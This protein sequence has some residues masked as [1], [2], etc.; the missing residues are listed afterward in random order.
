MISRFCILTSQSLFCLYVFPAFSKCFLFL[1]PRFLLFS[2]PTFRVFY[3]LLTSVLRG[4]FTPIGLIHLLLFS[5][6][7]SF[8]SSRFSFSSFLF[9]SSLLFLFSLSLPADFWCGDRRHAAPL[10]T[11]LKRG[12]VVPIRPLPGS[13]PEVALAYSTTTSQPFCPWTKTGPKCSK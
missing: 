3:N 5:P 7:L 6:L 4:C 13:A 10:P 1:L 11:G 9:L 8:F 2:A 12:G